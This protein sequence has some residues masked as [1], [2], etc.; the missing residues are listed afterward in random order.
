MRQTVEAVD[1][2]ELLDGRLGDAL[3]L[4]TP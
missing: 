1:A 2:E 4:L 3:V